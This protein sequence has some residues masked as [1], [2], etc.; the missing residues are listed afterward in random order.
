MA[1][2][3]GDPTIFSSPYRLE[4]IK[5]ALAEQNLDLAQIFLGDFLLNLVGEP[6]L[7]PYQRA[8]ISRPLSAPMMPWPWAQFQQLRRRAY[9]PQRPIHYRL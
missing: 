5:E 8:W 2:L 6:L 1:Y 7:R 4:G 3:A 9:H